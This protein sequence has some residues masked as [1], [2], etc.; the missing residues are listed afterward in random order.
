MNIIVCMVS[1]KILRLPFYIGTNTHSDTNSEEPLFSDTIT[2]NP[3]TM[4]SATIPPQP[5]KVLNCRAMCNY[6]NVNIFS[7]IRST[8]SK[9]RMKK[10]STNRV[11]HAKGKIIDNNIKILNGKDLH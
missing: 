10:R 9:V 11:I 2:S 3:A 6:T 8:L 1:T 5:H 7:Q 4:P